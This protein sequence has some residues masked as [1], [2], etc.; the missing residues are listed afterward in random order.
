MFAIYKKELKQ[1][2]YSVTGSIFISVNLFVLGLYFLAGNL[3]GMTPSLSPVISGVIFILMLMV[4]VISMRVM[5]EERRQ[6]TDQLL[7][8]SPVSVFK[9]V[10]GKYF[11]LLTV[12]II[13]VLVA[14]VLP[15]IMSSFGKVAYAE[16][17][18][19]ILGYFLY[20]AACLAL[21]LTISSVTES[22]VV[23]AVLSFIAL[24]ITY[25]MGGIVSMLTRSGNKLF[26]IL[27][28]LDFSSKLENFMN[29]VLDL[30]E[31]IY[32]ISIIIFFLFLTVQLI[33]KRRYSVS[34]N[35]LSLSAYS[36]LSIVVMAALT[37]LINFGADKIPI[38][39]SEFDMTEGSLFTLNPETVDFL[40]KLESDVTIY[41]MGT[42]ENL[43]N[44][45]Y[46]EVQKTLKEFEERSKHIKLVYKDP[47]VEPDFAKK[48]TGDNVS[49]GS[50]IVV[51]GDRNKVLSPYSL[52]QT[53]LDYTTYSQQ[54][55][56]YDGEGQ[57]VSA[58]SFVTGGDL[59]KIYYVTG[60]EELKP[61]D[62]QDLENAVE[63]MNIEMAGINL[64]Q[65]K[66]VPSDAEALLIL[67]PRNDYSEEDIKTLKAYLDKGGKAV[68]TADYSDKEQPLFDSFLKEYGI[69]KVNGIVVEGDEYN[70][71]QSPVYLIPKALSSVLTDSVINKDMLNL[72]PQSAGFT[73]DGKDGVDIEEALITS[74]K[75][76]AKTAVTEGTTVDKAEGD[77]DGPFDLALYVKD[78]E[79]G[80]I[81][82]LF[83]T[84]NI[85]APEVNGRVGGANVEL[86]TNALN[87][88]TDTT[89]NVTIPA[90]SY[91]TAALTVPYGSAMILGFLFIIVI[92]LAVLIFGI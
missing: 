48:Y 20:G 28:V 5:A 1:Y 63:K 58:V 90:K 68:I 56:G 17:Y 46:K 22:Q 81:M 33:E 86:F 13:P 12:F 37:V 50:L 19:A 76:Y 32:F 66:E 39:Y 10:L 24:F 45:D 23:A 11:A 30:K 36:V 61:S 52:Y 7:L 44:Y 80:T 83:G 91:N 9:I 88:M 40:Q 71:Y 57:I 84:A 78:E 77:E 82:A 27:S 79:K 85:F 31:I 49:V 42:E 67:S 38:K 64:M 6:K 26:E 16:S 59:P 4:P 62:F 89:L 35:T 18:T 65:E 14:C 41:V 47:A 53:E 3:L 21:G 87:T 8:T 73:V 92:P 54:R 75:A 51:S 70:M 29:G 55:T 25:I 2:L 74:D 72:F 15:L 69:N 60:H 34:K 43:E